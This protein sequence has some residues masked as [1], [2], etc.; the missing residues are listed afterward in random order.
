ME[1]FLSEGLM[2]KEV[3]ISRSASGIIN[4]ASSSKLLDTG[5]RREFE[6]QSTNTF[7]HIH[8]HLVNGRPGALNH[9]TTLQEFMQASYVR[10]RLQGLRRSGET[11]ADKRRAF[12]SIKEINIGGRCLCSGHAARCRYSVQHRVSQR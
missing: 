9:S 8:T 7:G 3:R 2:S 1:D 5:N 11:I 10:L 6:I 12:Y 4:K